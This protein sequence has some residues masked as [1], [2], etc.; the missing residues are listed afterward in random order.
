LLNLN[1]SNWV[2][3]FICSDLLFSFLITPFFQFNSLFLFIWHLF[4]LNPFFWLYLC[5][6][7]HFSCVWAFRDLLWFIITQ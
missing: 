3:F 2:S 5:A 1:Q 4:V 6:F 7:L